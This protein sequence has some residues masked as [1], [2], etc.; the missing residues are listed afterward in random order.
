MEVGGHW[1]V[2]RWEYCVLMSIIKD[3]VLKDIVQYM[4]SLTA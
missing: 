1:L 2:A 4:S 3:I